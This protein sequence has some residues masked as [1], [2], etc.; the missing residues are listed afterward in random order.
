MP[1]KA[2]VLVLA[3][4][5]ATAG[6]V[7]AEASQ[8]RGQLAV[9]A[10]VMVTTSIATALL[11]PG[12]FQISGVPQNVTGLPPTDLKPGPRTEATKANASAPTDFNNKQTICANVALS[13]SSEAPVRINLEGTGESAVGGERCGPSHG[14]SRQSLGLCGTP[15][16]QS[17]LVAVTI[18]Y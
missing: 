6:V 3:G 4:L 12:D 9:S 14:A 8:V 10:Y 2:D 11:S 13:C 5:L 15:S 17:G 18:E 16:S 1:Q 7:V